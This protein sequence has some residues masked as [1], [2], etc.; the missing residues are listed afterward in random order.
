MITFDFNNLQ[1]SFLTKGSTYFCHAD[2]T[3][4]REWNSTKSFK[5]QMFKLAKRFLNNKPRHKKRFWVGNY[6]LF[7]ILDRNLDWREIQSAHREIR[8]LFLEW[9]INQ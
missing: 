4:E 5:D 8:L 3:F 1:Q 6:A 2:S 9:L 7:T